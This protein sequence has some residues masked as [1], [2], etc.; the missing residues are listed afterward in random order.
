MAFDLKSIQKGKANRP[1]R[2]ILLGTAKVGKSTFASQSPN[3]IFLPVKGE[4]GID[5]LDVARF[6]VAQTL[7]DV[8]AAITSLYTDDHEHQTLVIDSASTLEPLVWAATCARERAASIEKVGGGYG[9]GYLEAEADWRKLTEGLDALRNDRDMGCILIGHI[10]VASFN[11][12]TADSYDQF[13]W[14]IHKRA[15]GM[16]TKWADATLFA[17]HKTVVKKEDVGGFAGEKRRAVSTGGPVLRTR[18]CPAHPGGGRGVYG[19]LPEELPLTWPAFQDAV[20][21]AMNA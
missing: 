6:P 12:P 20:A 16:L 2:L 19:H 4:E 15:S 18:A 11:D 5:D 21:D 1:P 9:K 17:Q 3:P 14:D 10:K 7:D 8:L 13:Q